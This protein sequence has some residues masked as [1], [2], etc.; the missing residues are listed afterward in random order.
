VVL[1]V[2]AYGLV[3]QPVRRHPLKWWWEV[4]LTV[5]AL[6]GLGLGVSTL[7]GGLREKLFMGGDPDPVP[8]QERI[9][10][11]NIPGTG[12]GF[13]CSLVYGQPYN[14]S[15]RIDFKRCGR[16]GRP[17]AGELFLL[18]DS[19]AL[20]LLPMVDAVTT[21]TGQRLSFTYQMACFIDPTMLMSWGNKSYGPCRQFAAGEMERSLQRLRRGDIV[22][23]AAW[24]NYYLSDIT[25][26][27]KP[28]EATVMEG[29]R[30]LTVSEARARHVANL[31][32]Y[33]EQLAARGIQLVL[34][35]DTPM[36]ARKLV[37]CR[38]VPGKEVSCAPPVPVTTRMQAQVRDTMAAV[39]AGLPNVHVFDPTPYLLEADGRVRYR[40]PDGTP[41]Y[42]DNHHLSV[43][44]SRSLA[45]PF[46][47]F[48]TEAGLVPAGR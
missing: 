40:K 23:I 15:T 31:R 9:Q 36:L 16:P 37:E 20:H 32:R 46:R 27:G 41:L 26:E 42:A 14:A 44:G 43:S 6:G 29:N 1:G 10:N 38:R 30:R 25:P 2:A 22:V 19:H 12:I 39:A 4:A 13:G 7:Q 48:L 45:E 33:A 47:R 3:E 35:V 5:L 11:L 21:A 24:L 34:V 18:C 17:G 28:T 8:R